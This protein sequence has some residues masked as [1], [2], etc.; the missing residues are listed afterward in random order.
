MKRL[1]FLSLL[2]FVILPGGIAANESVSD[3]RISQISQRLE[4]L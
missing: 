1:L 4:E 2:A 3:E